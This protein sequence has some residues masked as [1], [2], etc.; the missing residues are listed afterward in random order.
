MSA[1]KR[2]YRKV[3]RTVELE[4]DCRDRRLRR[5]VAI[6]RQRRIR[7]AIKFEGSR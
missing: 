4:A 6:K 5:A 2:N 3:C 1:S 7:Q